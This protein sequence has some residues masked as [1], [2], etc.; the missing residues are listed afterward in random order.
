MNEKRCLLTALCIGALLSVSSPVKA[1]DL[2]ERQAE[3]QNR[4][5]QASM[6]KRL[7][8]KDASKL[9]G[10]LSD[11]DKEKGK[12]R[13]EHGGV[14]SITDDK[15]LG[16]KLGDINQHFDEVVLPEGS[17]VERVVKPVKEKPP[18]AEKPAKQPKAEKPPKEAKA[19]K[20]AKHHNSSKDK[21][22]DANAATSGAGA[23]LPTNTSGATAAPAAAPPAPAG[24]PIAPSPI[25]PGAVKTAK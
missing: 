3:L 23:T 22:S 20:E 19:P 16:S 9:H 24:T 21:S 1:D 5:N 4:I 18:K 12:T 13:A 7:T 8:S 10:E 11:F 6:S 2:D 15:N 17:K 25:T 14:T